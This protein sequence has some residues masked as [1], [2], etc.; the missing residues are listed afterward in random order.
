MTISDNIFPIEGSIKDAMNALNKGVNGVL[1]CVDS[2][3]KMIGLVTDGDIRRGLLRNQNIELCISSVM[4]KDFVF[5]NEK[6]T[7]QQ[8]LS[9]LNSVH[10]H[11][12]ILDESGVP[13]DI[14]SWSDIW[15][16]PVA[17]PLLGGNELKYVQD[18]IKTNWISSQG[19][20]VKKF[21]SS[22][23]DYFDGISSV[24]VSSGT[25]ALHL[26][27]L[28]LGIGKEDEVIVPNIT[29]GASANV[30]VNVG[31]TP[32][33]VD[34]ENKYFTMSTSNLR[35]YITKNT[36][37][38]MPVHLYGHPCDMDPIMELAKENNL[39]VI[40]DCAEALGAEYKGS[41]VGKIGDIGCFSFFANKIITT[42]E[43]GM[44][45]TKHQHLMDKIK[46]F[47]DHGMSPSRRYWH[48][49]AGLNYRLTNLQA[50]I[51]LAQIEQLDKFLEHRMK[52]VEC[53]DELLSDNEFFSIPQ[54]AEWAKNV[55]WLYTIVLDEEKS[56]LNKIQL[57][58]ALRE[59]GIDTRNVF[60]P[61]HLQPAYSKRKDVLE[62]S[63][64]FSKN[65]L[66]LPLSNSI[67]VL[68]VQ[69]ACQI[70]LNILSI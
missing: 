52:I 4:K 38:I 69:K 19:D 16:L 37:A 45:T 33:F 41:K 59:K 8:N 17:A 53:Y 26:A 23:S 46:L 6:N 21:E 43:G 54:T 36:K 12:P 5:G 44:V 24:S 18:C 62:N 1:L 63:H 34:I 11:I 9:L 67:S 48:E 57:S 2:S 55:Y 47:R 28:A 58:N 39:W 35:K 7:R 27:L 66:S 20:Y 49:V 68:D 13:K 32:I 40:E 31:A 25:A 61:L 60:E 10:K 29:F 15:N 70:L 3:G 42:G 30:V 22:F 65:G 50:A 51:G 56:P 64:K 14:I